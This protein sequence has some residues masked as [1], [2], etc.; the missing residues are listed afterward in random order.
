MNVELKFF[1]TEVKSIGQEVFE[2]KTVGISV[3]CL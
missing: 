1:I 2:K 3:P